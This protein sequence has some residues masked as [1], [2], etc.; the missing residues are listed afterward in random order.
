MISRF[1]MFSSPCVAGQ[2]SMEFVLQPTPPEQ[3]RPRP[4]KR[5]Q[6]FDKSTVLTNK[7][8]CDIYHLNFVFIVINYDIGCCVAGL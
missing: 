6:F 7:Y 8:V 3:P 2:S 5:K 1:W 4:R